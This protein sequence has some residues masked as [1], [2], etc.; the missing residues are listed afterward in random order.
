MKFE[1]SAG[2]FVYRI[3]NGHALLLFLKRGNDYDTPKGHFEKGERAE[4]T[5]R[6]EVREETGLSVSFVPGFLKTV[7]MFFYRNKEKIMKTVKFFLAETDEKR[8]KISHEHTG[9]EWL[10][11]DQAMEKI[12]Y[13]NIKDVLPEVFDYIHRYEKIKE[14]NKEYAGLPKKEKWWNLSRTFVPGEGSLSAEIM[15][16]GQAP[17]ANED[18]QRRPFVGRSGQLL[19]RILKASRIK[20]NEAYITSVVQFFPPKNRMP[21]R[22]EINL[23]A[24][25]LK[26]Q[27]ELIKP[28]YVVLLG[29][30]AST[31][32]LGIGNIT[33]MHGKTVEK[34]GTKYFL[35]FHPAAAL[36]FK[37]IL[38]LML[39]DFRELSLLI[40]KDAGNTTAQ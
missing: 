12:K 13:K 36:R 21:T 3:E 10:S 31:E 30:V 1:F 40:T 32:V 17:G 29:N 15:L 11:M 26:M 16:L 18:M 20:R 9:Y 25:F 7:K 6:R 34:N 4:E 35:T 27:M 23:C 28:K 8:I 14:I 38:K 37:S 33:K 24:P 2:A 22:D 39:S 19:D 5:A